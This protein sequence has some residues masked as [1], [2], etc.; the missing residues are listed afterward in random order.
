VKVKEF[1][2]NFSYVVEA[3]NGIAR[4]REL[5]LQ[6]AVSGGLVEQDPAEGSSSD[7]IEVAE[8]ERLDYQAGLGLRQRELHGQVREDEEVFAIPESWQWARMG[9]IACYIQRGKGPSYASRGRVRVISQKCVQW[10]GFDLSPARYVSDE[11]LDRYGAERF[12]VEGDLLWNSTGTGTAGR[13]A[14]FIGTDEQAVAD[15]HV[16]VIRLTNFLPKYIWC[17]LASPSIQHR[18]VPG[19]ESSLVS[20]TTNQVELSTSKVLDLPVP[21]PPV[22]EQQRIVAKADE[23]MALCDKLEAQQQERERRYLVVSTASFSSLTNQPSSLR[24]QSIFEDLRRLPPPELRAAVAMLALKGEISDADQQD[25]PVSSM[26]EDLDAAR[27]EYALAHGIKLPKLRAIGDE[28][29]FRIKPTWTWVRLKRLFNFITDGDHQPPPRSPSGI[30]FLTI[31]NITTG[32]LD[33]SDV[34]YVPESYYHGLAPYRRPQE[35]DILYTVVG[36]TYGRPV[37]VDTDRPFCVQRHIAILKPG[38]GCNLNFLHLLLRSPLLYDQA[39]RDKTGTAQPTVPLSALR[40]FLVPLPPRGEQDRIVALV[41]RLTLSIDRLADQQNRCREVAERFAQ[42]AV[43]AITGTA[44][45]ES[46]PMKAPKTELVTRLEV[47]QTRNRQPGADE[48]LA[49]LLAE[50]DG[51]LTAK[52]LWQ[53]SGLAI[54]AFY[55]QLKTEMAAGWILEPEPARLDVSD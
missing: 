43:A 40:N 48:P 10:S 8:Q 53:R 20:G 49:R 19:A 42:A 29:P 24:L 30:A 1:L 9:Q 52:A 2:E 31:G 32:V 16:T 23:L 36:A 46:K 33:F 3:P 34:R 54:D 12:L 21:C 18:V 26:L 14:I 4:L 55:Q 13:V 44:P 15:S 7:S 17:Y 11:F 5:I 25:A 37:I 27:A 47:Y 45:Q 41:N 6:L 28:L 22:S 39:T 51:A 50:H 38:S 35:G